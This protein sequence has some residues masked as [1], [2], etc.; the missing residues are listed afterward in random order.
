VP[1]VLMLPY[2]GWVTFASILNIALRAMN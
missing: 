1:G 2:L